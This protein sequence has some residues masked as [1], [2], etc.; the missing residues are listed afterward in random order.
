MSKRRQRPVQ[1]YR[2]ATRDFIRI[3]RDVLESDHAFHTQVARVDTEQLRFRDF[4][5]FQSED[6][7][8][9]SRLRQMGVTNKTSEDQVNKRDY[10]RR[11]PEFH[12]NFQNPKKALPAVLKRRTRAFDKLYQAAQKEIDHTPNHETGSLY[13]LPQEFF[14]NLQRTID[15]RRT[16]AAQRAALKE[17][18]QQLLAVDHALRQPNLDGEIKAVDLQDQRRKALEAYEHARAESSLHGENIAKRERD[19]RFRVR[20]LFAERELFEGAARSTVSRGSDHKPLNEKRL[21]EKATVVPHTREAILDERQ[22][23]R[24]L[25]EYANHRYNKLAWRY[26]DDIE[27]YI[28]ENSCASRTQ[29][30]Q[31]FFDYRNRALADIAGAERYAEKIRT[32]QRSEKNLRHLEDMS[33]A[34]GSVSGDGYAESEGTGARKL[35]GMQCRL[36]R[37]HIIDYI[38][39]IDD[40]N[41]VSPSRPKSE[42]SYEHDM[43]WDGLPIEGSEF[44][45]MSM[46]ADRSRRQMFP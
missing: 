15:A 14:D 9:I 40:E 29:F 24:R 39:Q 31:R 28:N 25:L 41:P 43:P 3:L 16:I 8:E 20:P 12:D 46:V 36:E 21:D 35:F 7:G 22:F 1:G 2:P 5:F 34:F 23:A 4:L 10:P 27:R 32:M 44:E 37:P 6:I 42:P 26:Y 17:A 18:R 13:Q 19:L 45:S 33:S 30:D 38:N 11:Y